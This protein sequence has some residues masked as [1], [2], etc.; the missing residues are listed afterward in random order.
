MANHDNSNEDRDLAAVAARIFAVRQKYG[1]SQAKF[2]EQLGYSLRQYINWENGD[3]TPTIWALKAIRRIFDISPDWILS[4]P[5]PVPVS[6]PAGLPWDRY[7]RLIADIREM[8]DSVG[9]ELADDR[10]AKLARLLF[11]EAP[12]SEHEGRK[13]MLRILRAISL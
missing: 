13:K 10:I 8:V 3:S 1:F 9:M 2:A 11:E 4:G 6:H 5:G 7:D 12:E